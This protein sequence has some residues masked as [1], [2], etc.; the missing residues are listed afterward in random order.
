MTEVEALQFRLSELESRGYIPPSYLYNVTREE[1][2]AKWGITE[3]IEASKAIDPRNGNIVSGRVL[4]EL[5][6]SESAKRGAE[7]RRRNEE[8]RRLE[9][10]KQKDRLSRLFHA[11][12]HTFRNTKLSHMIDGLFGD[13]SA[14]DDFWRYA[15]I[16]EEEFVS[17]LQNDAM[18]PSRADQE[19]IDLAYQE[20]VTFLN[21]GEVPDIEVRKKMSEMSDSESSMAEEDEYSDSSYEDFRAMREQTILRNIE[22]GEEVS[23]EE[24][25]DYEVF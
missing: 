4:Q 9:W 17:R 20:W 23:D 7:T 5:E 14:D 1:T 18:I 24:L 13:M 2:A 10:N 8:K 3:I 12:L 11:L 22:N 16:H 19:T 25:D 21:Y 15:F 6:R